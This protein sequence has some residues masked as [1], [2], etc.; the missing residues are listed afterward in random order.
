[1]LD[2]SALVYWVCFPN[3]VGKTALGKA[4]ALSTLAMAGVWGRPQ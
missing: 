3:S 1:M 4:T 2:D